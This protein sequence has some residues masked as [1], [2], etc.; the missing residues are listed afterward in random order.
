MECREIKIKEIESLEN[1]IEGVYSWH[2]KPKRLDENKI[3]K[4]FEVFNKFEMKLFGNSVFNSSS[5]FG[6]KFEGELIRLKGNIDISSKVKSID[7]D[8]IISFLNF[9]SIPLYIGRSKNIKKR[10][11]QHYEGYLDAMTANFL[12][13]MGQEF[14]DDSDEESGY[15]GMRL[16]NLN[17]GK[18]F[19]DNELFIK[20]Y[21]KPNL[22]Y[23][24]VKD[25][26]FYLNRLY[27]PILGII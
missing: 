7:K 16:A 5:K 25:I 27:R 18:W 2:L 9:N 1:E 22:D 26:E 11:N 10:L 15:F 12:S 14:E 23:D 24:S 3:I 17:N 6:D 19:N 21:S 13:T 4:L 8:F 20:Y